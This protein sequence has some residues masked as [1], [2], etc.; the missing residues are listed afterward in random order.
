MSY[1][2]A[3]SRIPTTAALT[4]G[5]A[6]GSLDLD[7]E[8]ASVIT[9]NDAWLVSFID[10]LILLLTL[11][12]LLL[13]YQQDSAPGGAVGHLSSDAMT[14]A[15]EPL[16]LVVDLTTLLT[17]PDRLADI[18]NLEEESAA[19]R[20]ALAH[21]H[22]PAEPLTSVEV[23]PAEP[24]RTLATTDATT[25]VAA[26]STDSRAD[27]ADQPA[28]ASQ[29]AAPP[30]ASEKTTDTGTAKADP[31]QVFLQ[32]FSDH[33]LR[34]RVEVSVHSAGVNL[35]ISESILF[36]P[37]S[38]D[39]TPGGTAILSK[40]ADALSTQ[41]Y[42]LSVEG[43]TDSTPIQTARFPSNW[44]LSTARASTVARHLVKWGVS[45]ERI[46]AIGYADTRPRAENL[47]PEGRSRNRRVSLV[48]QVPSV[49]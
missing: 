44:E 5:D 14:D 23:L 3:N 1:A 27:G 28:T 35:E 17:A 24:V 4:P 45:A 18:F 34:D 19:N 6:A 36:P 16:Q 30:E 20:L 41:P 25:Q 26:A 12:V 9:R 49:Q 39:L 11:F 38:A 37:A 33:K 32:T 7:A 10:I 22:P 31:I 46:R 13:T 42:A 29:E 15:D 40:L 2:P 47:T 8:G 21:Q 48:V 43:H